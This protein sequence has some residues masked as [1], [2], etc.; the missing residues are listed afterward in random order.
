[1]YGEQK[2]VLTLVVESVLHGRDQFMVLKTVSIT[3]AYIHIVRGRWPEHGQ[4]TN[5]RTVLRSCFGGQFIILFSSP[6]TFR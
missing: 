5:S 2:C 4:N 6:E 1:M 3:P